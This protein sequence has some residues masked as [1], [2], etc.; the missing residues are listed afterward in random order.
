MPTPRPVDPAA[1]RAAM[2]RTCP[3]CKAGPLQRCSTPGG[4]RTVM[5]RVRVPATTAVRDNA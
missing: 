4:G 3:R 1:A 2:A 5:H